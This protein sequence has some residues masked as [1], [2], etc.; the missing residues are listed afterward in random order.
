MELFGSLH[1]ALVFFSEHGISPIGTSIAHLVESPT[2]PLA[3]SGGRMSNVIPQA[4]A[5]IGKNLPNGPSRVLQNEVP[6]AVLF[7]TLVIPTMH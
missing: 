7:L 2:I 3:V 5:S 1:K 4:L 6:V